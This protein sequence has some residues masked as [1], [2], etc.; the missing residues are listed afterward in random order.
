MLKL[1]NLFIFFGLLLYGTEMSAQKL[2]LNKNFWQP[3]AEV[4]SVVYDS[5]HQRFYVGGSFTS[6]APFAP[7]GAFVDISTQERDANMPIPDNQIFCSIS[8]GK[9]GWYIG[10]NF[11]KVG[12]SLRS[13]IAHINNKG[14]VTHLFS[15]MGFDQPVRKMIIKDSIL[16]IGGEFKSYGA[17]RTGL[18]VF[19]TVKKASV[20]NVTLGNGLVS[21]ML[22]DGKGGWYVCGTFTKIG[23]SLR[24][25]LA[26]IDSNG[27]VDAWNPEPVG[28]VSDI[29]IDA[30]YLYVAGKFSAIGGYVRSS[31]ASIILA[32][33]NASSWNPAISSG[34]SV[35]AMCFRGN[36]I[37]VTGSFSSIGGKS[38]AN[39]AAIDIVSGLATNWN[40]GLTGKV[41][42]M[43]VLGNNLYLGGDFTNV[44]GVSR[45]KLACVSL[46]NGAANSWNPKPDYAVLTMQTYGSQLM[47]G[48][49]F[50]NLNNVYTGSL[51]FFDTASLQLSSK[52]P[53]VEGSISSSYVV[54]G[55]LYLGGIFRTVDTF[56]RRNFAVYDWANQKMMPWEI[57]PTGETYK[58]VLGGNKLHISIYGSVCEDNRNGLAAIN[59]KTN[60]LTKWEP[61]IKGFTDITDMEVM[62]DKRFYVSGNIEYMGYKKTVYLSKVYFESAQ[63]E[64]YII[65]P[66][67]VVE[68]MHVYNGRLF[69]GGSFRKIGLDVRDKVAE[70]D[71]ST[72]LATN[73]V[74]PVFDK[75]V[76]TV[77]RTDSVLLVGGNFTK[78]GSVNQQACAIINYKNP[79]YLY[80]QPTC[81]GYINSFAVVGDKIYA[82]G[83][84]TK[85][86]RLNTPNIFEWDRVKND[87]TE[88]CTFP[89]NEVFNL[90]LSDDKKGFY[91]CG[92][93][94]L[95]GGQYR[96]GFAV[97]N[98]QGVLSD[99]GKDLDIYTPGVYTMELMDT[100]LYIGGKFS[101]IYYK[102]DITFRDGV[103]AISTKSSLPLAFNPQ[104]D[105]YN[106]HKAY[107]YDLK[108]RDSSLYIA[109]E[110]KDIKGT[111]RRNLAAVHPVTGAVRPW[112]PSP[113]DFVN[114]ML[115]NDSSVY[116]GGSFDSLVGKRRFRLGAVSLDNNATAR[117]F[118]PVANYDIR[119]I[120]KDSAYIYVAGDFTTISSVSRSQ[121]VRFKISD[122]S[123]DAW[124]PV[125]N[126]SGANVKGL[127][128]YDSFA[129]FGGT[130]TYVNSESRKYLASYYRNSNKLGYWNPAFDNSVNYINNT[131]NHVFA[132]GQFKV[133][134]SEKHQYLAAFRKPCTSIT[135]SEM[136]VSSCGSY[137]INGFTYTKSGYYQVLLTNYKGCDS[138]VKLD[139]TIKDTSM[140]F[141]Q[142]FQG[143]CNPYV[144]NGQSYSKGGVY[145]QKQTNYLGCDSTIV[146]SL[147]VPED[148]IHLNVN[149]C[150]SFVIG[151]QTYKT[152]G[153]YELSYTNRF[154][155]DSTILLNLKVATS[156]SSKVIFKVCDNNL[157]FKYNGQQYTQAGQYKQLT[158]TYDGCDS[159][160]NITLIVNPTWSNTIKV[161]D[162]K[163][164]V[165]NGQV[166]TTSGLYYSN[167]VSYLNCDSTVV[168]DFTRQFIDV[169]VI[170][171]GKKLTAVSDSCTYQWIDC[172]GTD[173]QGANS[174][175]FTA[176]SP[177]QYAV[178]IGKYGCDST[179]ACIEVKNTN[180]EMESG[181]DYISVYPNPNTGVFQISRTIADEALIIEIYDGIGQ[182]VYSGHLKGNTMDVNLQG[183]SKGIYWIRINSKTHTRLI[184][185]L[186]E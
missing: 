25:N 84:F 133:I 157:P 57:G 137:T 39:I 104:I 183:M 164:R 77:L 49:Y 47:V 167:F 169:K 141:I 162:C 19:D 48:G 172:N 52:Y 119:R 28:N 20:S 186:I 149:S 15:G 134:N 7:F 138:I 53:K 17:R 81:D 63:V 8:D 147:H 13:K 101:T 100:T 30:N 158:T 144:L 32:T 136:K 38:R 175:V 143:N 43:L 44:G 132:S 82:G 26:H 129:L 108:Y 126:T 36:T 61:N 113:N 35:S 122:L 69:I 34:G 177:G 115:F 152:S 103:M 174:K 106:L 153:K 64:H 91:V 127:T 24:T 29:L 59:I 135:S 165:F 12:D 171:S 159:V 10:G 105:L 116:V 22:S 114:A 4:R 92:D 87:H 120:A 88:W 102:G 18:V 154:G 139:L 46:I 168:L 55:K 14:E 41:N 33:G 1:S 140:K 151:G 131:G 16:Y 148:T 83:K 146:L 70:I 130:F 173:I 58:M 6:M 97:L 50:D 117:A 86:R 5:I 163:P 80:A 150:D 31:L 27:V 118:A 96:R 128:I 179:S 110:F 68:D 56:W 9:G 11:S 123:L 125:I 121:I 93:F 51:V 71:T 170:K 161:S 40:P 62:D 94:S 76:Y 111:L 54:D 124:Q 185:I 178:R 89:N 155:C 2:Q 45:Q 182:L 180:I 72:G 166:Y 90:S 3:D 145:Y 65:F 95:I 142:V 79:Q 42:T 160:I 85:S 74:T 37:I 60:K 73:F 78:V 98:Q 107:V 21:K 176:T 109:G 75:N 112:N 181:L 66:D 99:W 184:S 156:D 23:D 67:S